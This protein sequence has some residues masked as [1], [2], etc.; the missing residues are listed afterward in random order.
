[1]QIYTPRLYND[2]RI[3]WAQDQTLSITTMNELATG[4]WSNRDLKHNQRYIPQQPTRSLMRKKGGAPTTQ[5]VKTLANNHATNSRHA[6]TTTTNATPRPPTLPCR[7]LQPTIAKPRTHRSPSRTYL[8]ARIKM[9]GQ[10]AK[11][12]K[13]Q[14]RKKTRLKRATVL[15]LI[16][17]MRVC[18][19]YTRHENRGY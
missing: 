3:Q 11:T 17:K 4:P 7:D 2:T 13:I 12:L 10:K 18:S 16:F 19:C 14:N 8:H 1:M 6:A 5:G 9:Q 15:F